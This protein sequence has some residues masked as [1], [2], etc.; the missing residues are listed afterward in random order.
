MATKIYMEA[1][2]PTM[3]EGRV[4]TWLKNEGDSVAE[5]DVL[6]EVETDKA[7]MELQARGE[8]VLRRVLA[9]EG[10][11]VNVGTVIGIIAGPDDDIAGLLG[12]DDG[13]GKAR[14]VT[15]APPIP[16]KP[17]SQIDSAGDVMKSSPLARRLARELD[18]DLASVTGTGP[19]GRIIKRDIETLSRG[20]APV[21]AAVP[22]SG[23]EDVPLT[24]IRKTIAS[25]LTESLG[26]IPHFFLTAE[27]D[28]ERVADARAALLAKNDEPRISFNDIII[29]VVAEGLRQHRSCNAWWQGDHIR[30]FNDVHIGMAVAVNDGLITPVIRNAHLKSLR[31]IAADAR[32]LAARARERRLRPD[33]YTGSTFSVSNLGMLGIDDFTAVINPPEAGIIAIGAMTQRPVVVNGEVTVRRRLKITMSCDHRVIDGATGARFLQTV[34]LMLENPLAIVW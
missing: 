32:D 18:V 1:L 4:V 11:T 27:I 9:G 25:R 29:K 31:E 13:N 15:E 20:A 26:P 21:R 23:F 2:S 3:E 19:G 17:S 5:G 28:M 22:A 33:E 10:T 30:Y 6:A 8:G 24:Q 7:I 34:R 16:T 12:P 14:E